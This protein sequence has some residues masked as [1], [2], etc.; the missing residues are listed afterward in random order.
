[1]S[2]TKNY[3]ALLA[4]VMNNKGSLSEEKKQNYESLFYLIN[5]EMKDQLLKSSYP[6]TSDIIQRSE[7]MLN[8]MES[9]YLV[10]EAVGK[11]I[12]L[13]SFYRTASIFSTC[14]S[15]FQDEEYVHEIGK[16]HTQIP[17]IISHDEKSSIELINYANVRIRLSQSE[18]DFLLE[19]SGKRK[20]ALNRIVQFFIVKTPMKN[21]ECCLIADNIYE[22]AEKLFD[23]CIGKRLLYLNDEGLKTVQKRKVYN[24][25]AVLLKEKMVGKID[26]SLINYK[27]LIL[28]GELDGYIQGET[29]RVLY[30]FSDQFKAMEAQILEYYEMQEKKSKKTLQAVVGDIVRLDDRGNKLLQSIRHSHETQRKKLLEEKRELKVILE[31]IEKI[32]VEV[33][34]DLG[35]NSL[36]EK[37]VPRRVYDDVFDVL[38]RCNGYQTDL[39]ENVL[40]RLHSFGYD[41]GTLVSRYIQHLSGMKVV[42][43]PMS[44]KRGEWEKAK[45]IL[46][47]VS[48]GKLSSSQLKEC[49]EIL[50]DRI[51]TGKEYYLKSEVDSPRIQCRLLKKSFEKGYLEAGNKLLWMYKLGDSSV[52]L[53]S[54]ANGLVPEA[55]MLLGNEK[56]DSNR[57][58]SYFVDLSDYNLAYYK[59]AAACEYLPAI[60]ALIQRVYDSR[61]SNAFQIPKQDL[62]DEKY[63]KMLEQ[64]SLIS[65]L[66]RYLIGKMY[67]VDHF[68]EILGVVQFCMNQN[69]SES[70]RLLSGINT[71]V[72]NY[73][74]G[75][76]YEFGAGVSSDLDKAIEFYERSV[77]QEFSEIADKRLKACYDKRKKKVEQQKNANNYSSQKSYESTRT[78]TSVTTEDDSCFTPET[79]ILMGN[80]EYKAVSELSIGDHVLIYDHYAGGYGTEEIVANVHKTKAEE[81]QIVLSLEFDNGVKLEI[82]NSHVLFCNTIH[83]YVL[84]DRDNVKH[85]IGSTFAYYDGEKMYPVVLSEV[86]TERKATRYFAP[87]SKRHLN[88]FAEGILTMPPTKLTTNMFDIDSDMKYD[89]SVVEKFGLTPYE[90]MKEWI[91]EQEYD[92]LP[93]QYLEAVLYNNDSNMEDFIEILKLY[94]E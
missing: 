83:K 58:S 93:C 1:M 13:I 12:L 3:L 24:F 11:K 52:N 41:G 63:A 61:F 6:F 17:F 29:K 62:E 22:F 26:P 27:E 60:G 90:R 34:K 43:E 85:Y 46:E 68:S 74:Q 48:P 87:I 67:H 70:M 8:A 55:C 36:S 28:V 47:M 44:V 72:S 91:S 18:F 31:D 4:K 73:C 50:G 78:I 56:I 81:L 40:S 80:G 64:G 84:L 51:S 5:K 38:F 35:E 20:I 71:A 25:D 57:N 79:K 94:R 66:C 9:L 32:L 65:Q 19:E 10:P 59:I 42:C 86:K 49:V 33:S 54:L 89:L 92:D 30:G 77:K 45:M 2:N 16:T 37:Y 21:K 75:N 69:L 23:V 14:K 76:M 15:L 39:L 88:V 53:L 7:D 82:V